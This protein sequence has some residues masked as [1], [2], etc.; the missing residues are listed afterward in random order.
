MAYFVVSFVH[1]FLT[2]K[3]FFSTGAL[4]LSLCFSYIFKF[5]K[6]THVLVLNCTGPSN[7]MSAGAR[8][9]DRSW[10]FPF[11]PFLFCFVAPRLNTSLAL[12]ALFL[13]IY[14]M[15]VWRITRISSLLFIP[16]H[17]GSRFC[18]VCVNNAGHYNVANS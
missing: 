13:F 16:L 18:V 17:K 7:Q 10:A 12:L 15:L 1:V 5:F 14:Y 4:G 2:F 9:T 3:N 8:Q 6:E 11:F